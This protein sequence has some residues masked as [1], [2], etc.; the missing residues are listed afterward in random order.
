MDAFLFSVWRR[1]HRQPHTISIHFI[2]SE[3]NGY[4]LSMNA[5]FFISSSSSSISRLVVLLNSSGNFRRV[6]HQ[7][8]KTMNSAV[9]PCESELGSKVGIFKDFPKS[10]LGSV[11]LFLSL[12]WVGLSVPLELGRE[13]STHYSLFGDWREFIIISHVIRCLI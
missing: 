4:G 5:L 12:V 10:S 9:I 7:A 6:F 1:N 13:Y 11:C 8:N 2:T 3:W